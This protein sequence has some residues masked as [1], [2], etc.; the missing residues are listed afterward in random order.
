MAAI[1]DASCSILRSPSWGVQSA[2]SLLIYSKHFVGSASKRD[3]ILFI[4]KF[5][6]F[7]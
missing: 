4:N 3:R 6:K 2:M 7:H 5:S 1:I